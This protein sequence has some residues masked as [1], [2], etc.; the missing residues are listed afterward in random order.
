MESSDS[1]VSSERIGDIDEKTVVVLCGSTKATLFDQLSP[2]FRVVPLQVDVAGDVAEAISQRN[3]RK[4]S[5]VADSGS[6]SAALAFALQ[7]GDSLETLTLIAPPE[8]A[9]KGSQEDFP[10][11]Q[12]GVP[13]LVLLGTGDEGAA[14]ESGR[15]YARRIPKCFYILVYDAGHDIACDRPQALYAVLRDFLDYRE[16]FLVPHASSVINP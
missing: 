16:K 8:I 15:L 6:V 11:E 13:T 10:L 1:R 14:Q 7:S 3:I 9:P 12:I 4:F 2:D 5:L